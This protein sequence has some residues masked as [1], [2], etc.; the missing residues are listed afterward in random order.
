MVGPIYVLSRRISSHVLR[1]IL[2]DQA[3]VYLYIGE[4]N[5]HYI[6]SINR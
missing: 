2:T 1:P 3:D 5:I 4:T 6:N